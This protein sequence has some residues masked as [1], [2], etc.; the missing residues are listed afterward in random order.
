MPIVED[1]NEEIFA[2]YFSSVINIYILSS[3]PEQAQ[4]ISLY[5][6]WGCTR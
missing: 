3:I 6:F 4:S 5:F 2:S 1:M